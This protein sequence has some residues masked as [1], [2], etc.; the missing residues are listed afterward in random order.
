MSTTPFV[1][2]GWEPTPVPG[3]SCSDTEDPTILLQAQT[4]ATAILYSLTGRQFGCCSLTVRP[5][6]PRT[7]DPLQLSQIIYWDT[8]NYLTGGAPNLGVLSFF[9]TLINGEIYNISCGCPTGC[10]KC[11]ADCEVALPGPVC[12]VTDVTVDGVSL[13]PSWYRVVDGNTLIFNHILV[14]DTTDYAAAIA[15]E[16][17]LY[18][19]EAENVDSAGQPRT[20]T[21]DLVREAKYASYCPSCQDYNLPAGEIGTWTV[22]YSVGTPV[23][24]ELNF[25]AGLYANEIRK[26]LTGDKNCQLPA[27]VQQVA[28][29]GIS[30]TFIDPLTLTDAGL[31]GIPLVDQII[32]ALNPHQL[33]S[34]P[35]VWFPGK[36][37]TVRRDTP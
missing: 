26:S 11:T 14:S 12:T 19:L 10:C 2:C 33:A 7:C 15:T 4:L 1:P 20:Y 34:S 27:R 28:R 9:P 36:L 37:T 35:R 6:K 22:T 18:S 23:P 17:E 21:P 29:Q 5:C 30:T 16:N 8:R 13:D 32:R 25:A 31:T 3:A 24:A